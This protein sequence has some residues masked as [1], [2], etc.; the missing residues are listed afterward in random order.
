MWHRFQT[1][2]C[3]SR[4][5]SL[6]TLFPSLLDFLHDRFTSSQ[7]S[8]V[9]ASAFPFNFL[10]STT[11]PN[12]S[13]HVICTSICRHVVRVPSRSL[14]C[15]PSSSSRLCQMPSSHVRNSSVNPWHV[16]TRRPLLYPASTFVIALPR[17]WCALSATALQSSYSMNSFLA[18][19]FLQRFAP[20]FVIF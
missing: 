16:S 10:I 8:T 3:S 12:G 20:L 18:M 7:F 4:F 15:Q 1:E 13:M 14:T 5:P 6:F 19:S 9:R 2:L 17:S 11:L